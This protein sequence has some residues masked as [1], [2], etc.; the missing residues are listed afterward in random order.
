M[1]L[2]KI[3]GSLLALAILVSQYPIKG[4][5]SDT[6]YSLYGFFT[7]LTLAGIGV[8]LYN[9]YFRPTNSFIQLEDGKVVN[10]T[11][12]EWYL[13]QGGAKEMT[14]LKTATCKSQKVYRL[15]ITSGDNDWA[16]YTLDGK[17][18]KNGRLGEE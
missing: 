13:R 10:T 3:Y 6:K 8:S 5:Q 18:L 11:L 12:N 9:R 17:F 2:H 14:C 7:G 15:F 4:M 1:H 16:D